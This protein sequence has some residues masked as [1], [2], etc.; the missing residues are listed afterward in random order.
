MDTRSQPLNLATREIEL[1]LEIDSGGEAL[2]HAHPLLRAVRH[3]AEQQ[4]TIYYD[5]SSEALRRAGYSLRV[6]QK[7]A[8][9]VQ[10]LKPITQS[11]GL[12]DR[13]ETESAARSLQPD[14]EPLLDSPVAPLVKAGKLDDLVAVISSEMCRTSW[15]LHQNGDVIQVDFDEGEISAGG[16]SRPVRELELELLKGEPSSLLSTAKQIADEV[17][18]RIGVLTKAERGLRLARR[19]S[20]SATTAAA[21][22]VKPAMSVAD[23]FR[24][25]VH[26]CVKHYRLNEPLVI[27]RRDVAALHQARVAMRRL[28]AALSLFKSAVADLDYDHFREELRW[29][30][31]ELGDARNLD[32]YIERALPEMQRQ[33][34]SNRR[35]QAYARVIEA[36][37]SRRFRRLLIDLVAWTEFGHW[38]SAPPAETKIENYA[39][40][41]LDRL[42]RGIADVGPNLAHIDATTR[43]QLRIRAKKIRYATEFL[44]DLYPSAP[45]KKR[46]ASAIEKLQDAL[47]RLNDLAVAETLATPAA[48]TD[49]WLVKPTDELAM[50][51]SAAKAL[52]HLTSAGP[53]WRD[54]HH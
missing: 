29:F 42:W 15:H 17:P 8:T 53:F 33:M 32:V 4:L 49:D 50:V 35:D 44:N 11:V 3:S 31:S 20:D 27:D 54:R 23:S 7:G 52:R 12:L 19:L 24:A 26:A 14:L 40:R 47:G 21:V 36:M 28:R 51:D 25:I 46:F 37:N 9:F 5:T 6:R 13:D 16:F 22:H 10:T 39:P 2:V 41:R 30:A 1:K 18:V 38:R 34:L 45:H 43:H 48:G